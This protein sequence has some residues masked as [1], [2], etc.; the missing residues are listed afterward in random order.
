MFMLGFEKNV[1]SKHFDLAS[2]IFVLNATVLPD[3]NGKQKNIIS[4]H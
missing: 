4:K 2:I 3:G 1:T